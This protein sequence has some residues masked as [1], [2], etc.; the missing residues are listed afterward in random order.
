[1]LIGSPAG[2]FT[3]YGAARANRYA[4]RLAG[5]SG[6][7]RSGPEGCFWFNYAPMIACFDYQKLV[8]AESM[9]QTSGGFGGSLGKPMP[10]KSPVRRFCF[11]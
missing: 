9:L 4:S 8:E 6:D 1:M 3:E 5:I 2:P 10:P 7:R 11:A